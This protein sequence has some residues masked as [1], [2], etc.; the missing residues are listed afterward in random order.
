MRAIML[1]SGVG[2]SPASILT[3]TGPTP[4][5]LPDPGGRLVYKTIPDTAA[6]LGLFRG[7]PWRRRFLAPVLIRDANNQGQG[8]VQCPIVP[9]QKASDLRQTIENVLEET[10]NLSATRSLWFGK[11]VDQETLRLAA[12]D[13][14]WNCSI[15]WQLKGLF[16][17]PAVKFKG[18]GGRFLLVQQEQIGMDGE[19][20][21]LSTGYESEACHLSLS[22]RIT[23]KDDIV[24][25]VTFRATLSDQFLQGLFH[26]VGVTPNHPEEALLRIARQAYQEARKVGYVPCNPP[27]L[28]ARE[29][30]GDNQEAPWH[31]A[32]VQPT[33]GDDLW[34]ASFPGDVSE[35]I[36]ANPDH[37]AISLSSG[38]LDIYL[39]D[40]LHGAIDILSTD[41][42]PGGIDE[43]L[44]TP[45]FLF[46]IWQGAL[47]LQGK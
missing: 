23:S 36:H 21:Y 6:F 17:T 3:R 18:P 43:E 39:N 5:P 32:T 16:R 9:G 11:E 19:Y 24:P 46:G 34:K 41:R 15:L 38:L 31:E 33:G 8:V 22:A 35:A 20:Y 10:G 12:T 47:L 25:E 2:P 27:S 26:A 28:K 44:T 7:D 30:A 4:S 14:A 45:G 1:V 13:G 40:I 29:K 42:A 37:W